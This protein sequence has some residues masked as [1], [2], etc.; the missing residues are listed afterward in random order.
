M[1]TQEFLSRLSK[2]KNTG[3]GRWIACCPAHED[4][5]PS[6]SVKQTD[7]T[8]LIHCF[9]GCSIDS[10]LGAVGM[11][12]SD[13]YPDHQRLV[14]PQKLSAP[15]ALR[16]IAYE[17]LVVM[18]SAGTLRQRGLTPDEIGRLAKASGRIQASLEMAGVSE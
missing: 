16:C 13:L 10:I 6:M 14:K 3:S 15:D 5:S 17:A 12:V 11:D 18:A 2:V 1:K 4:K 9:A 8:I 7:E